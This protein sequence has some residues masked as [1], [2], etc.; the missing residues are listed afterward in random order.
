MSGIWSVRAL[1]LKDAEGNILCLSSND[2]V[3]ATVTVIGATGI[4]QENRAKIRLYPNPA[5]GIIYLSTEQRIIS[6][7]VYDPVGELIITN[8][9]VESGYIDLTREPPGLYI[10]RFLISG[11][12]Y[13]M[14]R[15][16]LY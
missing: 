1:S 13:I 16:L 9:A 8:K 7:N 4:S 11:D 14:K 12:H 2:S 6:Y 10:I 15:V 3:L 5:S